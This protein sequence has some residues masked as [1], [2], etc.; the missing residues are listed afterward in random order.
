MPKRGK[1]QRREELGLPVVATTGSFIKIQRNCGGYR[2]QKRASAC[3][4]GGRLIENGEAGGRPDDDAIA[5]GWAARWVGVL[6]RS[7]TLEGGVRDRRGGHEDP[8]YD[9]DDPDKMMRPRYM[10][11]RGEWVSGVYRMS[12]H[13]KQPSLRHRQ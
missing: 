5:H 4:R 10:L 3:V 12:A 11:E 2:V 7:S 9:V 8:P 6:P 1:R 13:A